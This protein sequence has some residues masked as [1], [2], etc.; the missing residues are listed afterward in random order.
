MSLKISPSEETESLRLWTAWEGSS[1][2]ELEATFPIRTYVDYLHVIQW[3]EAIGLR[4]TPLPAKLNISVPGGIRFSIIEDAQIQTYYETGKLKE[5]G[6][7]LKQ[8]YGT[9]DISDEVTLEEYG[10]KVKVRR[11]KSLEKHD[12]RVRAALSE[13]ASSLKTFRYMKRITFSSSVNPGVQFDITIVRQSKSPAPSLQESGAMTRPDHYEVEVEAVRTTGSQGRTGFQKAIV[14]VL[15]GLQ[16]SFV[17]LPNSIS[18]A[19][20]RA[21]AR[22]TGS[23]D[24]PGSQP[25]TLM[26]EHIAAEKTI[27]TPNIRFDDYNVTDKADG[28]RC[29][30]FIA[31]NGQV[32]LLDKDLRVYGTDRRCADPSTWAGALL[33]GEW[34]H[35]NARGEPVNYYYAFDIYNGRRGVDVT[36]RPFFV[37]VKDAET[38]LQEMQEV[39]AVLR[40]AAFIVK[41]IP[42]TKSLQIT[43]KTFQP[44]VDPTV[45]GGIFTEAASVLA[46]LSTDPP[47]HTDGLIF[48]PNATPLPKGRGSWA[49]QLKWKPAEENTIDFLVRMEPTESMK[50]KD[51][52]LVLC[53][54]LHLYVGSKDSVQ[55]RDP[56]KTVLEEEPLS[57]TLTIEKNEY[58]PVEFLSNPYDPYASICYVPVEDGKIYTSRSKDV[59]PNVSIVEMAY[60]PMNPAGF[61]WEPTRVRWDKTSRF[62]RGMI[63][64]TLNADATAQSIW[65]SI[66]EPITKDMICTGLLFSKKEEE[67]MSKLYYK[68]GL[69]ASDTLPVQKL[70]QFHNRYIKDKILLHSTLR[71]F[72]NPRLLDMSC[73]KGG[74][75]DKWLKNGAG[76][77]LGC[78]IAE[79]GLTDPT[80]SI[81]KRY[82]QKIQD[83]GGRERVPPM[84]FVQADASKLYADGTAGMTPEDRAMLRALWGHSE[85]TIPP[86]VRK[87]E[88]IAASGFDIV[89]IMFSLHYMFRDKAMF[90]GWLMNVGASLQVNGYLIGCCFDGDTVAKALQPVPEGSMLTGTQKGTTLWSIRKQ[91]DDAYTGYLPPTEMCLGRAI[92]VYFASIGD[93]YKEYLMSFP[94]LIK[95]LREIGCEL[96]TDEEC[97]TIGLRHS[98]AMFETSHK[99]AR[100][101]GEEY[102]MLPVIQEYS[103]FHRWFIFK[104]R[105]N[106]VIAPREA[107]GTPPSLTIVP[108][109]DEAPAPILINARPAPEELISLDDLASAAPPTPPAAASAAPAAPPTPLALSDVLDVAEPD[110]AGAAELT[111]ADGPLLKFYE[112]SVEKDD[113][114]IKKKTWARTLSTAAP[115]PFRDRSDHSI[116]YPNLEAAMAA[117]KFIVGSS[118]PDLGRTIFP[119]LTDLAEIRKRAKEVKKYGFKEDLWDS[120]KEAILAEYIYQ[121]YE[122]DEEFQD[123]LEGARVLGARLVFYTG[124]TATNELGGVIKGEFIQ[125]ENLYGRALMALVEMTY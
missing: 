18:T 70:R 37:R 84:I 89:S 88:G 61:R 117:E 13:W 34:I 94:Y 118:R 11:E 50:S 32:Y 38:R 74:D 24:F 41:G 123:I 69:S 52:S 99:M 109:E 47:Y 106:A 76:F 91:Y 60:H 68:V 122:V 119:S 79:S 104:R 51:D 97:R 42:P 16:Q 113:L 81:Y 19:V 2:L 57:T 27:G 80:D 9:K 45:P 66:H 90:D 54:T 125:G 1:D 108:V 55:Y 3:L 31:E 111:I 14:R 85:P 46:R 83:R 15:Q 107:T 110:V 105:T 103:Y 43:M 115:F 53:K 22:V 48:T 67:D 124:P 35:Q 25:A 75:L 62:Q 17:I 10:V 63:G 95:R 49:A 116:I 21:C 98:T 36:K 65:T 7:L 59:I 78:D 8:R 33:D 77:V 71:A 102:A 73:G 39:V 87:F 93:E 5:Y 6:V 92:E 121:R 56:R 64:R 114:K 96:L 58:K 120:Q 86:L 100:D 72:K 44:T 29:L 26:M 82:I 30:L 40:S 23:S 28:D 4:A 112:K 101:H 12:S 20:L